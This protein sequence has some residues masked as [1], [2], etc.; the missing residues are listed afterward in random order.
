MQLRQLA[1]SVVL[2]LTVI[3]SVQAAFA[4]GSGGG[5]GG[6]LGEGQGGGRGSDLSR[7]YREGV[8]LLADGECKKAE[9]KFRKITKA[10]SR[11]PEANY[12]RGM[13]LQCQGKYKTAVRYLKKAIRYD[14]EMYAAYQQL[15]I[16][17]LE[18]GEEKDAKGQLDRLETFKQGCDGD[19]SRELLEAHAKLVAAIAAQETEVSGSTGRDAHGLLFASVAEPQTAYLSAVRLINAQ[20]FEQAIMSLRQLTAEIGPHPDVLN[21]LGYASRRLGRLTRAQVYYEQALMLDPMH[22]GANEYLGELWVELGR[23]DEARVR[24]TILD[25]ACPF[26]CAEYEDLERLIGSRVVAAQ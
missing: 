18:L 11:N 17:Y 15:G 10:V 24:L 9:R 1:L 23:L 20:R 26:G 7:V 16:S 21:Y 3:V 8:Q 6:G 25:Q 2:V 22:R 13:A 19:C 4:A 5:G 12:M 14:D